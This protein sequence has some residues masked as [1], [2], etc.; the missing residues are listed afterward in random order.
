MK[1]PSQRLLRSTSIYSIGN[2]FTK[3]VAF[4][5]I[6]L[7]ARKL[8]TDEYGVV[9]M[10]EFVELLGRAILTFGLGQSV[11]RFLF[12]IRAEGKE[13]GFLFSL[14]LFLLI[15]N[16]VILGLCFLYPRPLVALFLEATPENVLYLRYSLIVL[17]VG[18]FQSIFAI[19]LQADEKAAPFVLYSFS[20]FLA[21]ILLNIYKVGYLNQ[22]VLG[23]VESKLI[24]AGVNAVFLAGYFLKRISFRYRGNLLREALSYGIPFIFTAISSTVLTLADRSIIK[25]LRGLSD[26]GIYG[27]SYKFAMLMNMLLITPFRQAFPPIIFSMSRTEEIN[28]TYRKFLTYYLIAGSFFFLGLSVF[29]REILL[30][31]ATPEYVSG[32]VIIPIISFSYLIMGMRL[33]F[34][35]VLAHSKKTRIIAYAASTGAFLNVLLNF[36]FIP[37]W[38]I[39]GAASATL[40]AEISI[41]GIIWNAQRRIASIPWD[42]RRARTLILL[43]LG[44]YAGSLLIPLSGLLI[45]IFVKTVLVCL[46][47]LSLLLLNFFRPDEKRFI[48]DK[49][50]MLG[51]KL[52][53]DSWE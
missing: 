50:K 21:L 27:M 16:V 36:L 6:P 10:L 40:L 9:V 32:Y 43:A 37:R 17:F 51:L 41:T 5:L 22:G 30:L 15:A 45:G 44:F 29:A 39:V 19:L 28:Q 53:L 4:V 31:A 7:Y 25:I 3:M 34:A 38:G 11:L 52:P 24:V 23:V 12:Q 13:R 35:N 42:W 33:V 26:V 20:N 2:L 8:Q 47:P 46:F 48:R 18:I 1:G 14:L 49:L